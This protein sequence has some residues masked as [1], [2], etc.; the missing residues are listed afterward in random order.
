MSE[1][2][3]GPGGQRIFAQNHDVQLMLC[4]LWDT[5]VT[6]CECPL[7]CRPSAG[8]IDEPRKMDIKLVLP[9]CNSVVRVRPGPGKC[10]AL[11]VPPAANLNSESQLKFAG[12]GTRILARIPDPSALQV[13][14][15]GS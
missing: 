15:A 1:P 9:H 14:Q 13:T 12:P 11:S 4:G 6:L 7:T 5:N 8:R 3:P 2:D 10:S